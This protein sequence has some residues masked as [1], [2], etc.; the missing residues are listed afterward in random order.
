MTKRNDIILI[1]AFLLL[2]IFTFGYMQSIKEEGD[3][4]IVK[5]DG[6]IHMEIPLSEDKSYTVEL[7]EGKYNTLMIKDGYVEMLEAS[8]PDQICVNHR[9]IQKSGETIVCLPNK[10]IIEIDSKYISE[11]DGIAN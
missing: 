8:C 4:V 7:S 2:A 1:I 11:I 6:E 10:L 9:K 5:L 3:T